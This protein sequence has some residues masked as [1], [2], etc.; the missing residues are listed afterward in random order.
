[1]TNDKYLRYGFLY[2]LV[3]GSLFNGI[4][5][6]IDENAIEIVR[7]VRSP[8]YAFRLLVY[9]RKTGKLINDRTF[10][11]HTEDALNATFIG[12]IAKQRLLRRYTPRKVRLRITDTST[13]LIPL[14]LF[15]KL[16]KEVGSNGGPLVL[17]SDEVKDRIEV[18]S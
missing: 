4:R 15:A 5:D 3:M 17:D 9:D 12:H 13:H 14:K 11:G 18:E 10:K 16:S 2:I 1:L 6:F 8:K 7:R